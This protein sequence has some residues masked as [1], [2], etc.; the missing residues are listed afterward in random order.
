MIVKAEVS[1]EEKARIK[2]LAS[3]AGMSVSSYL[4]KQALCWTDPDPT[5]ILKLIEA[6]APVLQRIG[7]LATAPIQNKVIFEAEIL[8]L[9]DRVSWI[10]DVT[11]AAVKEVL[12]NG[13]SG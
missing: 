9:L 4:K 5:P 7:E 2:E 3:A 10:E 13:H 12:K 11:A 6:Q 1:P 8:E